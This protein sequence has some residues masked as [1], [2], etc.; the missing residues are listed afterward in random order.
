M[1]TAAMINTRHGNTDWVPIDVHVQDNFPATLA[2]YRHYDALMVNPIFDGMN[3]VAKEGAL[4]NERD[5]VLIL[6]ENA[7]AFEELGALAVPVNPFDI[8]EQAVAIFRALTM[9]GDER[10]SRLQSIRAVVEG[11]SIEKW[12]TTQFADIERKMGEARP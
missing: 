3:L 1:E 9:P 11:N 4:I 8:E 5:G 12:V 2:A 10:R 6:S 7:G